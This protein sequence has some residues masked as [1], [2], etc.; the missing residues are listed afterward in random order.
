MNLSSR[1]AATCFQR[2]FAFML[3]QS[4]CSVQTFENAKSWIVTKWAAK[5]IC[6]R[7]NKPIII[8]NDFLFVCLRLRN[9]GIGGSFY[10]LSTQPWRQLNIQFSYMFVICWC[11]MVSVD[12]RRLLWPLIDYFVRNEKA[13][14]WCHGTKG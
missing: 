8:R 7:M 14:R 3:N 11:W 9:L 10:W 1:Y 13:Q 4:H 2:A 6:L 12:N 5:K